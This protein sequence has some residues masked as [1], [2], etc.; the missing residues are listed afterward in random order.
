[1]VSKLVK[2]CKKWSFVCQFASN[3]FSVFE[4]IV[5]F[6]GGEKRQFNVVL[7]YYISK[8]IISMV[9]KEA[10]TPLTKA[11]A[12]SSSQFRHG[13]RCSSTDTA[14]QHFLRSW[15]F[16]GPREQCFFVYCEHFKL[17]IIV[18]ARIQYFW[19][20]I[21][22]F[23][24]PIQILKGWSRL[25]SQKTLSFFNFFKIVTYFKGRLLLKYCF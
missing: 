7:K 12:Y 1:M 8:H 6:L 24:S 17:P 15:I 16:F 25:F 5:C 4:Q 10:L 18:C 23:V 2:I 9:R 20:K 11:T 22:S 3:A 19:G 21:T 14:C 13:K